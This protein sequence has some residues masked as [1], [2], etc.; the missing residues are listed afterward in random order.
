[1]AACFTQLIFMTGLSISCYQVGLQVI[2]EK[3]AGNIHVDNLHAILLMEGHFNTAMK[4]LIRACMVKN[5]LS[6]QL[7]PLGS[8]PRCTAI[9]VSLDC[10]LTDNLT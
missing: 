6:L 1:M 2:L 4:I 10:T 8:Q 5:S 7:I 9:Q 3:K